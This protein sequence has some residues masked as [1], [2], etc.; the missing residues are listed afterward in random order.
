MKNKR[1]L[2]VVISGPSGV[3]KSTIARQYLEDHPE[4]QFSTSA[5]TRERRKNEVQ[6]K[7]YFF[8]TDEEFK[9]GIEKSDFAEYAEVF[10]HL[11]GTP[12][13]FL[14]QTLSSGGDVFMDVDVKGASQL[15]KTYPEGVFIFIMPPSGDVLKDRLSKRAREGEDEI[16]RRLRKAKDEIAMFDK[17][18]YQIVNND[19]EKAVADLE[20]IIRAEKLKITF[21]EE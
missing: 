13:V 7:D 21:K 16:K 19:L 18:E 11:Y 9:A 15:M 3:G 14:E 20:A 17:Y 1:G 4:A 10:G 8:M 2:L 6:D 5:T 12:K